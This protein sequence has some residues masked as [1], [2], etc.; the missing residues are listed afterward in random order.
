LLIGDSHADM[1]I[2]TFSRIAR[3]LDATLSVAVRGGCPWQ[4]HLTTLDVHVPQGTFRAVDCQKQQ[5][6]LYDRVIPELAPDV[7]VAVDSAYED[8]RQP[9][10][11][12][13]GGRVMS[14]T[15][16]ADVRRVT[17]DSIGSLK[18]LRATGAQVVVLEPI[19]V[20]GMDQL[21]CLTKATYVEEC[22][23]VARATPDDLERAYRALD[24]KDSDVWSV[25]IDRL[26]CPYLPICDPI[27]GG[28]VVRRDGTHLS[29]AF[30]ESI[31]PDLERYLREVRVLPPR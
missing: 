5:D 26:V 23:Q 24:A 10:P 11:F 16:P 27:V 30:A 25:D 17:Q 28:R 1:L 2:P 13:A 6:D 31:A 21:G 29:V 18:Q 12:V 15:A 9:L 19:P 3:D 20:V 7:I 4:R 22:R 14:R 8:P